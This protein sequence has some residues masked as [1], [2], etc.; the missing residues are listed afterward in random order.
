MPSLPGF[1]FCCIVLTGILTFAGNVPDSF[2]P[3]F[4]KRESK[5]SFLEHFHWFLNVKASV[6]IT[7]YDAIA[8][9]LECLRHSLCFSF[10]IAISPSKSGHDCQLLGA[11]KYTLADRFQPSQFYHHYSMAVGKYNIR[12]R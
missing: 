6:S 3:G 9:A 8:C 2:D 7:V 10:N 1:F 4:G 5:A 11:D 12:V